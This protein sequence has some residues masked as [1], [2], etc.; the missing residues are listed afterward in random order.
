MCI[1]VLSLKKMDRKG[2]LIMDVK[3]IGFIMGF[4][5]I[6]TTSLGWAIEDYPNKPIQLICPFSVGGI[7]DLSARL[8]AE[9]MGEYLGQP[10]IVVN[11]PGAGATLGTAFVAAS[12]PDGYTIVTT[13]SGVFV[14]LPLINPNLPYKM[15]DLIPIGRSLVVN[16]LMLVNKDLPVKT[17]SEL[18]SYAK[19]NPKTL[20][21]GTA[22]VG[23]LPHLVMELLNSQAQIDIQHIPYNS[24]L[25][26]VT[27]LVGNHVQVSVLTFTIS[28][29]HIKSNAIRPLA[30]LAHKRDPILPDVPT[31][32]E[33]GFPELIAS[34]SNL[35]LAPAKIHAPILSKLE[36]ALERTLRDKEVK[37]KL[38]KME[39]KV[40]FLSG[41]DT[42]TFLENEVKRWSPV[43]KKANIVIK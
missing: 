21:Y 41:L 6:L 1:L 20:S 16:Q 30:T 37:E 32:G 23:S 19:K 9:K 29:S 40:E 7:T 38:E 25:Q 22:G 15:T 14:L 18:I 33:Q 28:L 3:K 12:K 5:F 27:A 39:Y 17:L 10:V 31:S 24:E 36:G 13:F 11:K 2:G 8:I 4:A 43:V 35:L 42:Q 26:A 34:I